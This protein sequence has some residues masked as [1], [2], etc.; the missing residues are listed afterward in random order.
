VTCRV[1][2]GQKI[3]QLLADKKIVATVRAGNQLRISPHFFNTE[4]EI[5]HLLTVLG[6]SC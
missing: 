4:E 6:S 3:A 5:D 1:S 2:D